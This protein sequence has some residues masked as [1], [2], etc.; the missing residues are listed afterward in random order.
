MKKSSGDVI[1]LNLCNKK[2]DHM[3]RAYS[4]TE[5]GRNK[6]LSFQA[7]FCS[8]RPLLTP[9]YKILKK[10]KKHQEIF[11]I[12]LHMCAINQDH[13][14]YGSWDIKVLRTEFF[15]V[16]GHFC[17][18]IFLATQKIKILKKQKSICRYYRF[19][20]VYHKWWSY[21]MWFLKYRARQTEFFVISG[22]FLPF[23][24]PNNPENQNFEK[25]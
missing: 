22:Y 25:L 3:M 8:F 19:T 11:Y 24:L 14:I 4:D 13:M 18:L 17:P 21:D 15:I 5:C 10:C 7:I 1:I 6:F 23:Y 16:L 2:N 12:L 9:K 20:P